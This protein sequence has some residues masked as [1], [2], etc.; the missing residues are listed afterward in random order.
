MKKLNNRG[1]AI[2]T[3]VYGVSIMGIMII[4]ILM[5]T[6]ST[7]LTNNKRFAKEIEQ[8]LNNFSKA[9]IT[10]KE[11]SV[12]NNPTPQE[13]IVPTGED[14]WYRI[15][16]WG[17]QGGGNG[18]YGSYTSGIINL[19]EGDRLY[20]YVGKH[21]DSPSS[22]RE[23]D[24]RIQSG[25]YNDSGSLATRIMV[26]AGGGSTAGAS[27]G[28]LKGYVPG[29]I[30]N[31]GSLKSAKDGSDYSLFNNGTN[32]S[33]VGYLPT[34]ETDKQSAT[35]QLSPGTSFYQKATNDN[36]GGDGYYPGPT[37]NVGG[38]SFIAGYA[39]SYA[40]SSSPTATVSK[41]PKLQYENLAAGATRDYYFV[42]GLML[43][44]VNQGD[45]LAKIERITLTD[46]EPDVSLKQ[47]A[48][49]KNVRLIRD[50]NDT[51][52][53]ERIVAIE[54]GEDIAFGKVVTIVGNCQQ[55]DLGGTHN[56]SEIAS[57]HIDGIDLKNHTI[58]VCTKASCTET[59]WKYLKGRGIDTELSETETATGIH[60][61]A[62]QPDYT[63]PLPKNGT[64]YIMPIL[65]E[66][67]VMT[68]QQNSN[69]VKVESIA[70]S[71]QQKWSIEE[72]SNKLKRRADGTISS[73]PEYKI[74]ELSR[75]KAL[76]ISNDENQVGSKIDANKTFNSYARN[77]PQIWKI[78]A[79]GNGTYIISATSKPLNSDIPSGNILPLPYPTNSEITEEYQNTL[80]I[81]RN[82][83]DTER[84][85][86]ISLEYN[87]K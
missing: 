57:W 84:F 41:D 62:Y 37:S 45:G 10:F 25:N 39:G 18:G 11:L 21:Q 69:P 79:V 78:K 22:G 70:G 48:K 53:A 44:G 23:T 26:A 34:Y 60:V 13:Y 6:M 17:T 56:I 61:S 38:L 77:E 35:T 73:D 3:I 58:A 82:N 51:H 50:C 1:F 42:D 24:V 36:G 33:L 8:E 32:G 59:E 54:E 68:A 29:M 71:K 87:K 72:I 12:D 31:G 2:T 52:P 85:K 30:A 49:F 81:G 67:K 40:Y 63:E 43:P 7:T 28:T 46:S 74:I 15:E 4:A 83:N 76:N 5:A 47:N 80:I 9:E 19:H 75:Y 16:L 14:G 64:Y 55:I 27:G 20:F 86:L 65:Y 66:N